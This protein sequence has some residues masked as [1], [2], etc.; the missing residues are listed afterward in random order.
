MISK[1]SSKERLQ[2]PETRHDSQIPKG[3]CSKYVSS[4]HC[5]AG[6]QLTHRL[7]IAN[8]W[9][10]Q[11]VR[12]H[13]DLVYSSILLIHSFNTRTT[14]GAER[15][16]SFLTIAGIKFTQI[17]VPAAQKTLFKYC[18]SIVVL[19]N[20][21]IHGRTTYQP[22]LTTFLQ[23]RHIPT[24]GYKITQSSAPDDGHMVAWNMLSNY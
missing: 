19:W 5:Q 24:Q 7:C 16:K 20:E 23:P 13:Y 15:D 2:V 3:N 10:A 6:W 21:P 12:S 9:V 1:R 4:S 14:K 17:I 22:D 18:S 11:W 8:Q